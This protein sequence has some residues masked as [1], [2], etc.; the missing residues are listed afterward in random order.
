MVAARPEAGR[1]P[2]IV[3]TPKDDWDRDNTLS[4][5][6]SFPVHVLQ[7]EVERF[8][9]LLEA[10]YDLIPFIAR[11]NLRQEITEPC[12]MVILGRDFE[13]DAQFSQR[14]V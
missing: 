3:R 5:N 12:I 7:K 9:P 1:A 2:L 10:T 11:K 13:H 8:K 6:F 14:R 4:Q